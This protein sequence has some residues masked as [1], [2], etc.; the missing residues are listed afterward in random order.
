[1]GAA[2]MESELW[3]FAGSIVTPLLLLPSRLARS[4]AAAILLFA[5]LLIVIGLYE[6]KAGASLKRYTSRDVLNDLLYGLFYQ[7]G[8]Y[9]LLV[10]TPFFAF[11]RAK[12]SLFDL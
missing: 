7:G 12:L 1:M 9:P 8:L 10:Y 3:G 2:G 4:M 5:V 11:V 6:A